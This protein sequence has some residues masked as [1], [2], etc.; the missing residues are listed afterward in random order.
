VP[1]VGREAERVE[2][3]RF[4][5]QAA[6]ERATL[7]FEGEAGIG[8][9]TL[10]D[11]VLASGADFTVLT[12]RCTQSE[13]TLGYAGLA[14]LIGADFG[15]TIERLPAPQRR[16]LEVAML[17]SDPG[18]DVVERQ[19]V[20]R[21]VLTLLGDLARAR[22]VLIGI[23]DLQWLDG[24]SRDVLAFALRRLETQPIGVVA[25]VRIAQTAAPVDSLVADGEARH[26]RVESMSAHDLEV[27]LAGRLPTAPARGMFR[28]VYELSAGNPFYALELCRRGD[29]STGE[30]AMPA[31]LQAL[32]RQRLDALSDADALAALRGRRGRRS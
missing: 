26:V 24:D 22:P 10:F 8:K 12:C 5:D 4:L 16:A 6:R 15:A 23:D 1:L 32:L 20:G 2:I 3:D 27:L 11:A 19:S 18:D 13:S 30:F 29:S 25:T 21:A 14:D 17:R 28:R 31:S 9:S 7:V